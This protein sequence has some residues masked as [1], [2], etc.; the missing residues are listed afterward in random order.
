[1]SN[2]ESTGRAG[3]KAASGGTNTKTEG[4]GHA[5]SRGKLSFKE[6]MWATAA[7]SQVSKPFA[8]LKGLQPGKIA[9]QPREKLS[10]SGTGDSG[11]GP[12]R[13][14]SG[15]NVALSKQSSTDGD[16]GTPPDHNT[17]TK[18]KETKNGKGNGNGRKKTTTRQSD[19]DAEEKIP[20]TQE[21]NNPGGR[22]QQEQKA[23]TAKVGLS[24]LSDNWNQGA[25]ELWGLS[26][27]T[28]QKLSENLQSMDIHTDPSGT[29]RADS[30]FSQALS[31]ASADLKELSRSHST[32]E[33]EFCA[34]NISRSLWSS[35]SAGQATGEGTAGM[36]GADLA[37]E[38]VGQRSTLSRPLSDSVLR[39]TPVETS[40]L[41]I[42]KQEF[43]PNTPEFVLPQ[44]PQM[45]Q[46]QSQ[47]QMQTP[48]PE[49]YQHGDYPQQQNDFIFQEGPWY[50]QMGSGAPSI[51]GNG[52][53]TNHGGEVVYD[54]G[55]RNR[56][57]QQ[58]HT[59]A[60]MDAIIS[61]TV[62]GTGHELHTRVDQGYDCVSVTSNWS[63]DSA[64]FVPQ[65]HL[66]HQRP[67][68]PQRPQ[69]LSAS[70]SSGQEQSRG[71]FDSVRSQL[72]PA[73]TTGEL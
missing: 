37:S 67:A 21:G 26:I 69:V 30:P 22:E 48:G 3:N 8:E 5:P 52:S 1:M 20:W 54:N 58:H 41:K 18:D 25:G 44:M 66:Q 19:R 36:V 24:A 42:P 62:G 9:I 47:M 23:K 10:R 38:R 17:P 15:E 34:T 16:S 71:R 49:Y 2:V 43:K 28:T 11:V 59:R 13:Q 55:D 70:S 73:S 68:Q 6:I 56:Y 46:S 50:P 57:S 40:Q 7:G 32:V 12:S 63:I 51:P 61:P 29:K 35:A 14:T 27:A 65:T 31:T 53:Y 45:S 39:S 4:A 33:A 64:P 72:H 60:P